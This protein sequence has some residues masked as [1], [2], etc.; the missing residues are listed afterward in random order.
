MTQALAGQ[1]LL[2][3]ITWGTRDPETTGLI[4]F[5]VNPVLKR[6][7]LL[8][9]PPEFLPSCQGH[10]ENISLVSADSEKPRVLLAQIEEFI[11]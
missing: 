7:E 3:F 9:T 5:P 4:H 11:F 1:M 10:W 6:R 8:L 2:M